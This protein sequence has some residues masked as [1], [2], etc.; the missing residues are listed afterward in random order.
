VNGHPEVLTNAKL[1]QHFHRDLFH[2]YDF[3]NTMLRIGSMNMCLWNGTIALLLWCSLAVWLRAHIRAEH[4]VFQLTNF[5]VIQSPNYLV[6]S[7]NYGSNTFSVTFGCLLA[8][9]IQN[10][11]GSWV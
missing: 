9:L 5:S 8:F 1:R 11:G 2:G 7:S 10:V 4:G 6:I 3:D